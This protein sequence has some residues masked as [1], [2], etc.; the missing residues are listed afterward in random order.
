ML[1]TVRSYVL[2]PLTT[3]LGTFL[4]GILGAYGFHADFAHALALVIL[5]IALVGVDLILAQLR[6]HKIINDTLGGRYGL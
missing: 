3:R 6:K 2:G 1:K 4:A 5:S